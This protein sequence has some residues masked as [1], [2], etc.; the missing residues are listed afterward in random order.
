[1]PWALQ[2]AKNRLSEVVRQA[3][4]S[5]PQVITLQGK[6]TAVVLSMEDFRRV[7]HRGQNTLAQFL[8]DSPWGESTLEVERARD[9]GRDIDL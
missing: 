8:R 7:T 9:L 4:E 3:Q 6:E 5:G 1:M 2:D